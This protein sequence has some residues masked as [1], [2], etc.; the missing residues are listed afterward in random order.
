M[1]RSYAIA[2]RTGFSA[3]GFLA[4][5]DIAGTVG[6]LALAVVATALPLIGH[7]AGQP[8]GIFL[9]CALAA[10]VASYATATIPIVLLFAYVFQNFFVSVLTP[11]IGSLDQFNSI[12]SYNFILTAVI[13]L[14]VVGRYWL[15][16]DT[17]GEPLRSIMNMM[18]IALIGIGFYF[19]FGFLS[20][21]MGATIYLR[22]IT[23]P[24]FLFQVFAVV[25]YR[26]RISIS[27][28]LVVIAVV[29]LL[30]G[31]LELLENEKWF[32]LIH[33]DGYFKWATLRDFEAGTWL[34]ELKET[35][36][37]Y[38]GYLDTTEVDFLNTPL[39]GDLGLRFHRLVGPNFHPISFAYVLA[40]FAILLSALGQWWYLIL[41]LPLLLVIGSKG[42]LLFTATVILAL[43]L[44]RRHRAPWVFW[45]YV[46]LL[47]VYVAIAI[48]TGIRGGDYHV[49]GLMG[50][51]KGFLKD[52]IG[53]GIGVG[54]NLSVNMTALDWSRF[55]QQGETDVAVESAVGVLLYQM[56]VAGALLLALQF[57]I[58]RKTWTLYAQSG[59]RVTGMAAIGMLSIMA[60]GFFQEE[61]LFAP[62]ALG[63][64]FALAGLMLGRAY[65]ETELFTT[66]SPVAATA[67]VEH[68][69]PRRR[70]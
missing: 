14:V 30:C 40:F 34:K 27:G 21:P 57:W 17:V 16:R 69:A 32:R 70:I 38:R 51:L 23:T 62:L 36:R 8:F 19:C 5:V 9:C 60:N 26:N 56:G 67:T 35:G 4:S 37:V 18:I 61:A 3:P 64:I 29:A 39:L 47:A 10:I 42:S 63:I 12:R 59:N 1:A 24:I 2:N 31:Y 41:A 11:E 66:V 28:A 49:I 68:S 33:G 48:S 20:N 52:P 43:A 45:L 44:T 7:L 25:A 46:G 55:Q 22:N 65:R 50:G 53:H 58:A 13:W 54:G 15:E 6:A